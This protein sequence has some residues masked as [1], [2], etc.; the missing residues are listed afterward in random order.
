MTGLD[1]TRDQVLE[2][3]VLM[4]DDQLN[5][6]DEGLQ[7][8][9]HQP[10]EVM[11]LMDEVV[12]KMHYHSGLSAAVRSSTLSLDEAERQALAYIKKHAENGK[13]PLCGN[14]IG[15]DRRFLAAWLPKIEA[16]LHY[17]VIDVTSIKEL[18][19]RWYPAAAERQPKKK[20]GH[21]ALDDVIESIEELRYWRSAVFKP[22]GR[23]SDGTA[24][25]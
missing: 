19:K 22:Q 21:R 23:Q 20:K 8:V 15:I 4:T 18:A 3:A 11:A 16:Y 1:H 5:P 13:E 9:V 17:H 24:S 25:R 14:S 10:P 12:S 2:I 6:I 7:L